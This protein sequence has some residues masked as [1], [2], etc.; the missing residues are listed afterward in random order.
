MPITT[1][2]TLQM[3]YLQHQQFY[4]RTFNRLRSINKDMGRPQFPYMGLVRVNG[5]L[6]AE[7]YAPEGLGKRPNCKADLPTD[8]LWALHT[9]SLT[10]VGVFTL[11]AASTDLHFS[12]ASAWSGENYHFIVHIA[13]LDLDLTAVCSELPAQTSKCGPPTLFALLR[14]IIVLWNILSPARYV[15]MSPQLRDISP[16]RYVELKPQLRDIQ[17]DTW[18]SLNYPLRPS[19][20]PSHLVRPPTHDYY[21]CLRGNVKFRAAISLFKWTKISP[22][23]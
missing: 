7:V 2:S 14:M 6:Q 4:M 9:V 17:N 11:G 12:V 16:A 15:E 3:C 1:L 21:I 23:Y 5:L 18:W 19:T 10:Q 13:S 8:P 20:W 22:K